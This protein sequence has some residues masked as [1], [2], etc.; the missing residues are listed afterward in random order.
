MSC[1]K[2]LYKSAVTL[3]LFKRWHI[4]NTEMYVNVVPHEYFSEC[5]AQTNSSVVVQGKNEHFLS[6]VGL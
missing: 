5:I 2:V 6:L 1:D 4:A 3:T